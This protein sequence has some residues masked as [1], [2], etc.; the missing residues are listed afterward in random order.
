MAISDRLVVMKDGWIE[1]VGSPIE[2]YEKPAN[3][4]IAGFVGYVNFMEGR[5]ASIC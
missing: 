5:I 1:Q 2:I 3:E 4:F